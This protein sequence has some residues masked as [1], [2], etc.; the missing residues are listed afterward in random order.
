[1]RIPLKQESKELQSSRMR[2]R[3]LYIPTRH[4]SSISGLGR[5][6]IWSNGLLRFRKS[7]FI[8]YASLLPWA[9]KLSSEAFG[10][11]AEACSQI[12][13]LLK[14]RNQEEHHFPLILSFLERKVP[15]TIW[16]TS[17]Q[18]GRCHRWWWPTSTT[19]TAG[20]AGHAQQSTG[21]Q[22]Q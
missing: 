5:P 10:H 22:F 13:Y 20:P 14:V 8:K 18:R 15:S 11:F 12:R 1:M 16:K 3:K 21:L 7:H 2:S 17:C 6:G 9:R 4:G 19:Y